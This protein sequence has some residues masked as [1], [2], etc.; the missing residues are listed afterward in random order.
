MNWNSIKQ[1]ISKLLFY[2][3][4]IGLWALQGS[5]VAIGARVAGE[6]GVTTTT[7][8][9]EQKTKK[10][11]K[12]KPRTKSAAPRKP[13]KRAEKAVQKKVIT[14]DKKASKKPTPDKPYVTIDFD[15]VDIS[16]FIKFISELTGRNFV[17]DKAV[18]GKVT[19]ISPTKISVKEAYRVFESVLVV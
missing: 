7:S 18:K 3:L 11:I 6:E 19:I 9:A 15:N 4:C 8:E 16:I 10:P 5:S 17:I 13:V 2:I 1:K 14:E 12:D